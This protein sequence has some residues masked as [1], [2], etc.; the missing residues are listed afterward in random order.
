MAVAPI[1]A[2]PWR[3][4]GLRRRMACFLYEGVLLFGVVMLVGLLYGVLTQQRHA[5]TGSTGLKTVLFA[6]LGVYFVHFWTRSGQTLAMVTWHIRLITRDGQPVGW[7]RASCRY[8][9]SW[10]WFLPALGLAHLSGVQGGWMVWTAVLIGVVTYAALAYLH[11]TRQFWH[12]VVC[13]TQL[14]TQLPPRLAAKASR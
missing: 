10:L 14:I 6:V 5:L 8:V 3:T 2:P 4:P 12:D 1:P 11:P 7:V 9:L 13:G